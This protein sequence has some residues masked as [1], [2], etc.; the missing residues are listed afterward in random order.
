MGQKD[1]GKICRKGISLIELLKMFPDEP[2]AENWFEE[3]R[4]GKASEP[5]CCPMCGSSARITQTKNRKPLPYWCGSCRRHFNVKTNTIMHRSK[6]PMRKWVIAM[7]L[8][9]TSLHGVSSL[10]LHRDLQ[11]SQK[12]AW[13]LA[14]RLREAW[15]QGNF[16]IESQVEANETITGGKRKNLPASKRRDLTGRGVVRKQPFHEQRT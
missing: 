13:F 6:I 8:W 7:F 12:S 2:T 1:P 15:K 16:G 3:I 10:K 4:W 9:S 14:H 11:I 5:S